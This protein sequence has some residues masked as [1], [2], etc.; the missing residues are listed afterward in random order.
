MNV[1]LFHNPILHTPLGEASGTNY[2]RHR[3]SSIYVTNNPKTIGIFFIAHLLL[4]LIEKGRKRD[5]SDLMVIPEPYA[6]LVLKFNT[7]TL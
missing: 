6:S 7:C 1:L 5:S 4:L 3:N 2:E